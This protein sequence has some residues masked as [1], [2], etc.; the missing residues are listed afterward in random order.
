MSL[1][2]N[3]NYKHMDD[4]ECLVMQSPVRGVVDGR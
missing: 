2:L 1:V 4:L 3:T